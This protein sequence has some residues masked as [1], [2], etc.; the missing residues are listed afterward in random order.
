MGTLAHTTW[1]GQLLRHLPGPILCL[2]DSWSEGVARRH[3]AKRRQA[4]LQ[5]KAP[6][7]VV[8]QYRPQ[9]WRD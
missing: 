3:A 1:V 5:R 9:P 4:W 7:A 6:K 8:P 2:L